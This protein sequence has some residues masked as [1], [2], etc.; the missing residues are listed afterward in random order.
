MTTLTISRKTEF[1]AGSRFR[2]YADSSP[3]SRGTVIDHSRIP[4]AELRVQFDGEE[5]QLLDNTVMILPLKEVPKVDE[6]AAHPVPLLS[7]DMERRGY[8]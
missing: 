1:P 8:R 2:L 6:I 3:R 7:P 5:S 4:W